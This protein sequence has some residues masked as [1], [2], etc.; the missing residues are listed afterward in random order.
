ML[1][2]DKA[3]RPQSADQVAAEVEAF[4]EGAKERE[5]RRAE[6]VDACASARRIR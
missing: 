2:K 6:A 1:S 3:E 4:L 5:R